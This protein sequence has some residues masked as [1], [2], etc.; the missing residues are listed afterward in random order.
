MS[1]LID[2]HHYSI[3]ISGDF[4]FTAIHISIWNL[5]IKM[6]S[7][8]YMCFIK[9]VIKKNRREKI[10]GRFMTTA[11]FLHCC[12]LDSAVASLI[13]FHKGLSPTKCSKVSAC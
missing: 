8:L 3:F 1:N 6:I 10:P 2:A 7:V 5:K 4:D 13:S 11:L 9:N 12:F